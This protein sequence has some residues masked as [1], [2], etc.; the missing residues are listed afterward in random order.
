MPVRIRRKT[1]S[2]RV[3]ATTLYERL[4]EMIAAGIIVKSANGY[5]LTGT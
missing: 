4:A 1:P 5:C 2:C 3:R